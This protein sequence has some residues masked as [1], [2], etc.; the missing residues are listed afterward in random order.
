[1]REIGKVVSINGPIV[2]INGAREVHM[3]ELV[4]VGLAHLTAEVIG[5]AGDRATVQVYEETSGLAPG[6]PVLTTGG[7]MCAELGP[8]LLEQMFDGILRPLRSLE[9][10]S[11]A[12]IGRGLTLPTLDRSKFWQVEVTVD[13]GDEVRPGQVVATVQETPVVEHRVLCPPD[14]HGTAVEAV[15]AGAYTVDQVLVRVQTPKGVRPILLHQKWPIRQAR[16][17]LRRLPPSRPLL[18]GQRVIDTLFPIAKG[19][20]A[21]IPGGFGTGKTMTQHQLAKWADA[22]VVVYI[23][24]GERGNEM[25]EVVED[26]PTLIDP[27]TG[28]PLLDRTVLIANTSNMPVA[29]RE[30][31]IY[32]GIT[33]AEYFRDMGYDVALMADS[34]SRWAEALR[35]LSGRL[36]EIPA[37]EGF[38]AYLGTR[39]GEFYERA[40]AAIVLAGSSGSVS[41][42]GAVSPPGGDFSEPVTQHTKRFIRCFWALDRGLAAARHYPAIHWLESYSDYGSELQPFFAEHAAPDWASLVERARVILQQEDDL[43]QIVKLVGE[44]VLADE[45]KLTLRT[46]RLLRVGFL[47]QAAHDKVDTYCP[48]AK[49]E[50]LLRLCLRFHERAGQ[51][52]AKGAHIVAVEKLPI[53][54]R[55]LLAKTAIPNDRLELFDEVAAQLESEMDGLLASY[56]AGLPQVS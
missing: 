6:E 25:T 2:R 19:G 39:L 23:G 48:L 26:F 40:G 11:G 38:P 17:V 33:V 27:R 29:A 5:L 20:T 42:I 35:E 45:Q 37:E 46:C 24:C 30:A 21:A 12:F 55:L 31:S 28:R 50:R 44:E 54:A 3:Y 14:L 4:Q 51:V 15:P 16:P 34:T 36:E 10:A 1:M 47:Q 13:V 7:P 32:A 56:E 52:I 53:A 49:Q 43:M 41:V 9:R 8:G 18:T 22:S